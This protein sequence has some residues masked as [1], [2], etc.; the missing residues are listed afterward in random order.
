[1]GFTGGGFPLLMALGGGVFW[2]L[3]AAAEGD[4]L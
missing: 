2:A 1:M 4:H 3:G